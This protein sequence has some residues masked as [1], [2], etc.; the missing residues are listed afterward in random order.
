M[1]T[2]QKTTQRGSFATRLGAIAAAVGSAVGLGNIWRFPYEAGTHG[3]GAFLI[4]YLAFSMLIG[5]PLLCAEFSIGR[6]CRANVVDSFVKVSGKKAWGAIGFISIVAAVLVLSFYSVVAGWTIEYTFLSVTQGFESTDTGTLHEMFDTFLGS[7]WKQLCCTW[8]FLLFNYL[9]LVRGASGIEKLSNVLMPILFLILIVFCVNSLLLPG[10]A[11][12]LKFLFAPDFDS[13]TPGVVLNAMGQSFFSLSIGL[14]CMLTYGSYFKSDANIPRT[15]FTIASLDSLVA[16]LAGVIIFPAVFSF[17]MTPQAGPTLVFE[18]VPAI[19]GAM[20]GG[21][22][23]APLFFILLFIAALT[24]TISIAETCISFFTDRFHWSRHSATLTIILVTM[25]LSG[26]C[27]LSFGP[28]KDF[29]IC[30]QTIFNLF[31]STSSNLLLP[32]GALL[33]AIF[34]GWVFSRKTFD[35]QISTPGTKSW[36]YF[37]AMHFLIR[38]I[39][40]VCL[41]IVLVSMFV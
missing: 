27:A 30:S 3:G 31:D 9:A 24:S 35:Q 21:V 22:I 4:I 25:A 37:P 7:P 40:P 36:K 5:V 29:T 16:I 26:L 1:A 12:G 41:F 28:M 18:T 17:G 19:F 13:I 23:F 20:P 10:A 32:V 15:A 14:G 39:I 38:Y 6:S 33:T 8:L 34:A 11:E 2:K